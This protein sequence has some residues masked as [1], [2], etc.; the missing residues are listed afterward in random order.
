M[1]TLLDISS[2][3]VATEDM[4]E[5]ISS[6]VAAV[7]LM[8]AEISSAAVATTLTLVDIC[9]DVPATARVFS[10][11]EE[12]MPAAFWASV[13]PSWIDPIILMVSSSASVSADA[14]SRACART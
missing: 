7:L 8:L 3:V 5:L 4:L 14:I 2:T 6:A 13:T 12:T 10:S 11:S 1:E 9:S